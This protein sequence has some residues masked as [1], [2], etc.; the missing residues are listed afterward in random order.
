L[1]GSMPITS[2]AEAVLSLTIL[3]FSPLL[4]QSL[5]GVEAR[6]ANQLWAVQ[7]SLEP[8]SPTVSAGSQAV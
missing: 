6:R 7:T 3:L 8:L 4:L 2:A 1:W 5:L